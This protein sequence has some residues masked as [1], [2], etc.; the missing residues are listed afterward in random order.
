M[1]MRR[2]FTYGLSALS[3]SVSIAGCGFHA[4]APKI[5]P[6]TSA[7]TSAPKSSPSTKPLKLGLVAHPSSALPATDR[8]LPVKEQKKTVSPTFQAPSTA[9]PPVP[10]YW[11]GSPAGEHVYITIDDGWT[12]SAQ[13][14]DLM[15]KTHLPLTAFLIQHAVAENLSY[16][17]AF[18][19]DGGVI[20]DHT[21]SHPDLATIPYDQ[22]VTQWKSP[23]TTYTSWFKST[24]T[25]GRPPYGGIDPTVA[26]AAAAS[27]L[28]GI[29]M[30]SAEMGPTGVLTW[31]HRPLQA[32]DIILL[33]WDKGLYNQIQQLL[34]II[35]ADHLT[36]APLL[37]GL[38][39]SAG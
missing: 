33:H 9:P 21:L 1:A 19:A 2:F 39:S 22:V 4:A 5:S 24:P 26:R 17:K 15:K 3:M 23:Y 13:V 27:G 12:P 20:E 10:I 18:Q 28:H 30:W 11:F 14:L 16:W 31:N 37:S 34:K 6:P 36:V 29:V 35:A 32:G 8:P 38:P 25:L 7:V